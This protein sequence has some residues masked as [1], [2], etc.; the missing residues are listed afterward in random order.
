MTGGLVGFGGS[1]GTEGAIRI[2]VFKMDHGDVVRDILYIGHTARCDVG[3]LHHIVVILAEGE[4]DAVGDATVS[5]AVDYI[6]VADFS[7]FVYASKTD[8]PGLASLGIDLDLGQIQ[9]IGICRRWITDAGVGIQTAQ[10][11]G[12]EGRIFPGILL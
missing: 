12:N 11:G 1:G 5:L 2:V 9:Y 8:D 7:D 10:S 6:D 4:A 3:V